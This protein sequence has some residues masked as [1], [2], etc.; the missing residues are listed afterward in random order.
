MPPSY[1]NNPG[2]LYGIDQ[3]FKNVLGQVN[4]QVYSLHTDT[5]DTISDLVFLPSSTEVFG[6][7]STSISGETIIDGPT[8][9]YYAQNSSLTAPGN[10]A[11]DNRKKY[12]SDGTAAAYYLRSIYAANTTQATQSSLLLRISGI[13]TTGTLTQVPVGGTGTTARYLAPCCCI[14]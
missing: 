8:Y 11:D 6:L 2:F 10:G 5:L 13:T 1:A 9:T 7:N 3:D 4:K 12:T 14:V